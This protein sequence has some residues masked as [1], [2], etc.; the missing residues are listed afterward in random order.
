MRRKNSV[1]LQRLIEQQV[2]QRFAP[3]AV[4]VNGAGDIQQLYG[5]VDRYLNSVP[6]QAEGNLLTLVRVD[7]KAGLREAIHAVLVQ[8]A[9][10]I[11][12]AVQVGEDDVR[13][14]VEIS[15][16]PCTESMPAQ[17]MALVAF[18][19]ISAA[20]AAAAPTHSRV[21]LSEL[22]DA[23]D[24]EQALK[25]SEED[26]QLALMAS[27]L[28]TWHWHIGPNRLEWSPAC[29]AMFG[30]PVGT[31]MNYERF[32]A[33]LHPDDRM[34]TDQ[35]VRT[36][37]DQRS[38]YVTEYRVLWP[39]GSQHW[40]AARGRGFYDHH[41]IAV[42]MVGVTLDVTA[43]KTAEL[44]LRESEERYRRIVQTA[45]EG[46]WIIDAEANTT[47]V[48]P[49]MAELLGCTVAEMQGQPLTSYMDEEGKQI[50]AANLKRRQQ[51]IV[52]Q[53]D[54]KFLRKDGRALWTLIATNPFFS[55]TG[56][57]A[58]A[59]AMVTDITER[60]RLEDDLRQAQKMEAVGRLAG[61][62]AH[63]FNNQLTVIH[64]YG[65]SAL[66]KS[67]N[68]A[69]TACLT[70]VIHAA[71][72]SAD[73][74]RQLLS[75]SRKDRKTFREV[76]V[77][78]LIVEMLD[79]LSRS[80]SKVIRLQHSLTA[81]PALVIGDAGLL[82]NALLNLAFN[83]RD[84]MPN[85]GELRFTTAPIILDGAHCARLNGDMAPG[86]YL[87]ITISDTGHG[88]TE[89]VQQHL[90]EPF[91]STKGPGKGTGLGLASVYGTVQ[92]HGGGIEV[93]S[94]LERG[95]SIRVF[96]PLVSASQKPE[97]SITEL[98][99]T[100]S[101]TRATI[102]VVDDESFVATLVAE[103]LA[104]E[105]HAAVCQADGALGLAY[106][107]EHWRTIDLIILDMNMPN[108]AGAEMFAA[109]RALNPDVQVLIM[110]GYS[111][112]GAIEL[113]LQQGAKGYIAKPF[114]LTNLIQR[115]DQALRSSAVVK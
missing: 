24:L 9:P 18:T 103:T 48:N 40:I 55:S 4:L 87:A 74:V 31:V 14:Q 61:G 22:A 70:H 112:E 114:T 99:S 90:F 17:G 13:C 113:L 96:L 37:L 56:A 115:V 85:G 25:Q 45:N 72:R 58:G 108:M 76:D 29:L 66:Q 80:V 93:D 49:K 16:T 15:L 44:A 111:E 59:M 82:Q 35:A 62:I 3:A 5:N 92:Q 54:F 65:T 46:I 102:L 39:N 101:A 11:L 73:L 51:G 100:P 7:L 47:F 57:Y 21:G 2:W 32:L 83:A 36:A 42:R 19:K 94:V 20:T 33:A 6:G 107:R 68:E 1:D 41:G 64:G 86:Q 75:F 52:E 81:T 71:E 67:P 104:S 88:M 78:D 79:V 91:F 84:A 106:Y 12:T 98:P 10:V 109:V 8:Q 26:L 53:H 27:N 89:D 30:I 50:A 110:S 38:D 63:D 43:R 28:G 95:T 77:H 34:P 97:V 60:R 69:V 23:R 105:G